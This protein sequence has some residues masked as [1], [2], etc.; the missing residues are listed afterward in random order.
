MINDFLKYIK[1]ELIGNTLII[2]EIQEK[3]GR[4]SRKEVSGKIYEIIEKEN[5]FSI[6]IK[7]K[8]EYNMSKKNKLADIGI[9]DIILLSQTDE[10]QLV[11]NDKHDNPI[12]YYAKRA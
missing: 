11:K 6:H 4:I 7:G 1:K 3:N 2:N 12:Y 10:I 9:I 5:N 8:D